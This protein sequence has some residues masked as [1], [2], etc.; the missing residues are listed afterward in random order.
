MIATLYAIAILG[1]LLYGGNWLWLALVHAR[2]ERLRPGPPPDPEARPEAPARW[3]VVTVQLPLYNEADVAE[4]LIDACARLDYPKD[5]LEIQV[6]DDSTDET[7]A[8]VRRCAARWQERGLDV[9]CLHRTE[10]DGYKAGALKNGLRLAR[11]DLVAVFDADFVPSPD[12]LRR[13]VPA[14]LEDE[15]VGMVQARWGHLN[16]DSSPL[17]KGQAFGLDAHFALEQHARQEAG[18]FINF[19]GTAGLWRRRCIEAANG[20]Q[21]DTLTEDLD[22]SYRAQLRGWRLRYLPAL[23][24]PAELPAEM[25]AL[26]AQQ[27]RW[28]KGAIET[29]RKLL[30]P[31]WRSAQ[32]LRTKLEGSLHL[33]AHLAYPLMLLAALTHPLLIGLENAGRGPGA[34]YF[35]VMGV[36]MVGFAGFFL[37][38]VFAQRALYPDWLHR[39][40]RF[41]LFAAGTI[42][43]SLSNT[44]AVVQAL[45]GR[46]TAFVRTPKTGTRGRR[47]PWWQ[48][49]YA[50]EDTP[51]GG[52]PAVVWSEGLL[53]LYSLAGVAVVASSGQWAA[54]PFQALF[55]AGFMLVSAASIEQTRHVRRARTA[56]SHVPA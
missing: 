56:A 54:L 8:L 46:R 11:G 26:R 34:L 33:T 48:S 41:P 42:G 51:G 37:A 16:A 4:R 44:R 19:N 47:R 3:P 53:S 9:S 55:A 12:F 43:L 13:A 35:A 6:L 14:L 29:A 10:R 24:V 50:G 7:T 30:G 20:W 52:L 2:A 27:H 23:E 36:G 31:L 49:R 40:W 21:T 39:L 15:G 5:R 17:T 22:L 1:L 45:R 38:Q 25:A 28:A 32:P 18:C